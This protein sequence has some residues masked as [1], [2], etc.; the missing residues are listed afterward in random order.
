MTLKRFCDQ[1]EISL[2][3]IKKKYLNIDKFAL[4]MNYVCKYNGVFIIIWRI[5]KM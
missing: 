1:Y 2:E 3:D 5:K 4:M